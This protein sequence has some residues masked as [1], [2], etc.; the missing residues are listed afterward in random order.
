MMGAL[1]SAVYGSPFHEGE[2]LLTHNESISGYVLVDLNGDDQD[3]FV[4]SNG[5]RTR[6]SVYLAHPDGESFWEPKHY[7]WSGGGVRV[8]DLDGDGILDLMALSGD[9]L[10]VLPGRGGD[11]FGAM[12]E[13][14]L[15]EADGRLNLRVEDFNFDGRPDLLFLTGDPLEI[16]VQAQTGYL[17]FSEVT[18]AVN[19]SGVEPWGF[20]F[21]DFSAAPHAGFF[22]WTEDRDRLEVYPGSNGSFVASPVTGFS[23]SIFSIG[24][25]DFDGDGL[26][27]LFYDFNRFMRRTEA[28]NGFTGESF[29]FVDYANLSD[30][31][32][33]RVS[34]SIRGDLNGDGVLDFLKRTGD[35]EGLIWG[36]SIRGGENIL[37]SERFDP[38][39]GAGDIRGIS[40]TKR[41]GDDFPDLVYYRNGSTIYAALNKGKATKN[42]P[43]VF[44][45]PEE[46]EGVAGHG[47]VRL[48]D[49]DL[50]GDLDLVTRSSSLLFH[51]KR[52][53][54]GSF[55]FV[56]SSNPGRVIKEWRSGDVDG[57]G[58]DDHVLL[59]Q[60]S[61]G[62]DLV[63][64]SGAPGGGYADIAVVGDGHYG[65]HDIELGDLDR[66]GDFDVIEF[67]HEEEASVFYWY[68]N[69][70]EGSFGA[71]TELV[72]IGWEEDEVGAVVR[73]GDLDGDGLVDFVVATNERLVWLRNLGANAFDSVPRPFETFPNSIAGSF[74]VADMDGDL[75]DE[76][77]LV[78]P[79]SLTY[80]YRDFSQNGDPERKVVGSRP[81]RR[82][83]AEDYNGDGLLDLV[84]PTTLDFGVQVLIQ[85]E[86][87]EFMQAG[88]LGG[89]QARSL[90]FGDLDG[91]GR[92]DF[93]ASSAAEAY[94]HRNV[95]PFGEVE[96]S[97]DPNEN[98]VVPELP[99]G[100]LAADVTGDG[101]DD[102]LISSAAN[103][104][105]MMAAG[106]AGGCYEDAVE[107]F[108]AAGDVVELLQGDFD[109]DG[110]VDLVTIHETDPVV[111]VWEN[112]RG[113]GSEFRVD[114]SS[115]GVEES[116]G[117]VIL[118][119]DKDARLDIV[120][121]DLADDRVMLMKGDG[122]GSFSEVTL[123]EDASSPGQVELVKGTRDVAV[124]GDSDVYYFKNESGPGTID[125][126]LLEM[127]NPQGGVRYQGLAVT[128]LEGDLDPDLVAISVSGGSTEFYHWEISN[129]EA[130]Q[131]PSSLFVYNGEVEAFE[132][133]DMDRDGREDFVFTGGT[134]SGS[135]LIHPVT[136]SFGFN[137]L[138]N[139]RHDVRSDWL[140]LLDFDRDGDLDAVGAASSGD[141]RVVAS[142][143]H[144][145]HYVEVP[146]EVSVVDSAADERELLLPIKIEH[147]G[148]ENEADLR[149][150]SI[151]VKFT[152]VGDRP[153][154][155]GQLKEFVEEIRYHR[156]SNLNGEFD[157][158]SDA[159][160][161]VLP[162]DYIYL[163]DEGVLL[164]SLYG[165]A[166]PRELAAGD[167]L[168]GF[169][170]VKLRSTADQ[171]SFSMIEARL[172]RLH[173]RYQNVVNMPLVLEARNSVRTVLSIPRSGHCER[174]LEEHFGRIEE[175]GPRSKGGDFDKDGRGNLLEYATGTNPLMWEVTP[176]VATMV[177]GSPALSYIYDPD[178]EL[179]FFPEWSLDLQTFYESGEG[180]LG[181]ER[182]IELTDPVELP[183]GRMRANAIVPVGAS[184]AAF[185]RMKAEE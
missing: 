115:S 136:G 159:A 166:G 163:D 155:G 95:S 2:E 113:D 58:V 125:V 78:R 176:E 148:D 4:L 164:I 12:V 86:R 7:H 62:V 144:F 76:V 56:D 26:V 153:L 91:D 93:V 133:G 35:A 106:E 5:P 48:I 64:D 43:V 46:I 34:G 70:G 102:L 118:D 47:E 146:A 38:G 145:D 96:F 20:E 49:Q 69:D 45:E 165:V 157:V 132:C 82:P 112:F 182:V 80:L 98:V 121:S 63:Y 17:E 160:T 61:A 23:R 138:Q 109:R 21:G 68:A 79:S 24:M 149:L 177:E 107:V 59:L 114:W 184:S 174:W 108:E 65:D 154:R 77:V 55:D 151:A 52:L 3:D 13:V 40:L 31:I 99:N 171:A 169:L 129:G 167:E 18:A 74:T 131:Q 117:G 140:A 92:R 15:G 130:S 152:T 83:I 123:T 37:W 66:D 147:T 97:G 142:R 116:G 14:M 30:E 87:G 124:R 134:A 11:E 150:E 111:V 100:V 139:V 25:D 19:P 158:E 110:D 156:D 119:F 72:S 170:S 16:S 32:I 173:F 179:R 101:I 183:D 41:R 162:T 8:V 88:D 27:D 122:L 75:A 6:V 81:W 10:R 9:V 185:L 51:Y 42:H 141:A 105:V 178:A 57:D 103:G 90:V 89:L 29:V 44:A 1:V 84:F 28:A 126:E 71:R 85:D 180:P 67:D 181:D 175:G 161:K 137:R 128:D 50:D 53:P 168:C 104:K 143:S 135:I 33:P 127:P 39:G 73:L 120:V 22:V 172:E 36:K 54:D 60:N 94:W